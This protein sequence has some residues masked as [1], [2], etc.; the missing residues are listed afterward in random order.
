MRIDKEYGW[1]DM[2]FEGDVCYVLDVWV[3]EEMRGKGYGRKLVEEVVE[4][5]K[6]CGCREIR[7]DVWSERM[8]RIVEKLGFERD[9]SESD[10]GEGYVLRL[11]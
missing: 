11:E 6:K 3:N 5:C 2:E 1:V 9:G 10:V 4:L 8:R 7:M